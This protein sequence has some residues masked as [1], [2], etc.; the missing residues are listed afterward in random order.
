MPDITDNTEMVI[1]EKQNCW[2]GWIGK[3]GWDSWVDEM[4]LIIWW[5]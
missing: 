4:I 3:K 1:F 5:L 2:N